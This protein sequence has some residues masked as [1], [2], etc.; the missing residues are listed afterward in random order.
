MRAETPSK[1]LAPRMK[2]FKRQHPLDPTGI[3]PDSNPKAVQR[4]RLCQRPWGDSGRQGVGWSSVSCRT[5][6]FGNGGRKRLVGRR[7]APRTCSRLNGEGGGCAAVHAKP[8]GA[9]PARPC[10]PGPCF[11]SPGVADLTALPCRDG[12][13]LPPAVLPHQEAGL[14]RL[15]AGPPGRD[16]ARAQETA[17]QAAF[18]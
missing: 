18:P 15:H 7:H 10:T 8:S 9:V 5:R 6:I 12:L 11:P 3:G 1:T 4:R 17:E 2:V 16:P 14:C 13:C